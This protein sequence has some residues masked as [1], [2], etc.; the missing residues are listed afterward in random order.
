MTNSILNKEMIDINLLIAWGAAY[1]KVSTNEIIF[2]EGTS[3]HNYH[4]LVSGSVKW[5]NVNEEGNEFI[6]TMIEPGEC[7]GEL[8]LFD[9]GPFAATALALEDSV[10]LRLNIQ[11]FHQLLKEYPQINFSFS[12]LLAQRVRFKFLLMKSIALSSPEARIS[13][14]LNYF[15]EENKN[16]CPKCHQIKLTRQQIANMTGLRVETVIR[17]MRLMNEKGELSIKKGKVFWN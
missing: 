14:L 6:Q 13:T 15:K 12:T 8:P 9:G 10:I 17:T 2:K 3:C 16:I 7:F 4:Q 1:K 5:V 11:S